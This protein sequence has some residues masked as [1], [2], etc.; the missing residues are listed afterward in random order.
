MY[1]QFQSQYP[2][3]EAS[4]GRY[5]IP[6]TTFDSDP[7]FEASSSEYYKAES[8]IEKSLRVNFVR[9]VFSITAIQLFITAIIAHMFMSHPLFYKINYYFSGLVTLAG[10]V[11]FIISMGLGFSTT[12]SR[13]VPL[14][15][16]LLGIFTMSE[17]YC[18][19]FIAAQYSREKVISAVY[20]T[21]VV[22]AVLAG[23]ALYSKTEITYHGG[24][25]LLIS[26]G[27]LVLTFFSW[28]TGFRFF[29]SLIY[30]GATV[31]SGLYLIYD[32]KLLMGTD[33]LKLSLDDYVKGSM[34]LYID[35]VKVFIN[36]LQMFAN[37]AEEEREEQERRER[38]RRER[39][40]KRWW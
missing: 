36:I 2:T 5:P 7:T 11:A 3:Q 37:K 24:L 31:M 14:N 19:G 17:A 29:D 38:E 21:A 32:V 10:F 22:V 16:I 9:K 13:R 25:I 1:S 35:I 23:Y 39:M 34:H 27:S 8:T 12:L 18:V 30:A 15:Y 28:L 6:P 33:R 20:L 40:R 4:S 26:L